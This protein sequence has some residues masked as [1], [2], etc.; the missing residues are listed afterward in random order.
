[1]SRDL[2]AVQGP[3]EG[4]IASSDVLREPEDAIPSSEKVKLHSLFMLAEAAEFGNP[5]FCLFSGGWGSCSGIGS[6]ILVLVWRQGGG[7]ENSNPFDCRLC[8]G[9]FWDSGVAGLAFF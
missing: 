7:F 4:E 8:D 5:P 3:Y 1:M 9:G 6:C 2:I